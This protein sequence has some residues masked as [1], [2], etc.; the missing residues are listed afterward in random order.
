LAQVGGSAITF[1]VPSFL[2]AAM[3]LA[4]PPPAAAEETVAQFAP[5]LELGDELDEHPAASSARAASAASVYRCGD[6]TRMPPVA[7]RP[8]ASAARRKPRVNVR[9]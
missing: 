3:S 4:I 1:S 5:P 6:L 9:K 8:D 2:A 7:S